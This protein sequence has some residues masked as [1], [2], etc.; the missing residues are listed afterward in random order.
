MSDRV[1]TRARSWCFT[2]NN[3]D[4]VD[5]QR[6]RNLGGDAG[7]SYLVFGREL[8][9][10]TGTPHLQGFVTFKNAK[11]LA[12][13]KR[14]VSD[15]A[16]YDKSYGTPDSAAIY[17]KKGGDY[18]E[19]G[20]APVGT[21]KRTDLLDFI[22]WLQSLRTRP[23]LREIIVAFPSL[24]NRS[25]PRLWDFV[26]VHVPRPILAPADSTLRPWQ[27]DL[28]S[29]LSDGDADD[30]TITFVVDPVGNTGKSFF[31][32]YM[33]TTRDDVQI[34]RVGKRDDLAHAIDQNKHIFLI[35][36]PRSQ[37]E[38]LQYSIL[39][40]LKDRTV[41]SPKY[42]SGTK[43]LSTTPYVVV[44]CNE[45]PDMNKLSEDRYDIKYI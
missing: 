17:C 15:R 6:L 22:E 16:H 21:G 44:F 30:R 37:M 27:Q 36:V 5:Q 1:I 14:L 33:M 7:V 13:V 25:G 38:F 19:F 35:D 41:F 24:Y 40:M 32:R 20:T 3:Y 4:D 23:S 8:A 43:V 2:L 28:V 42:H 45:A 10:T 31:C 29:D 34:L 18:E 26:D 12:I 11:V 39:E 9:P